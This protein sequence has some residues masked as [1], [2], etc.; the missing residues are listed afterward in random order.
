MVSKAR[1]DLPEPD[2]PAMTTS[3]S[4]GISTET[5]LRLWTRAPRTATVDRGAGLAGL[6]DGLEL[7][8]SFSQVNEGQLLDGDVAPAGE[9]HGDGGFADEAL[10]GE[11]FAGGGDSLEIEVA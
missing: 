5:F 8:R 3:L 11:V 1:L 6:G 4:R 9:L 7:I 10:I 2:N